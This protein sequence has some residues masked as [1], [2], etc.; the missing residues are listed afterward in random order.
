MGMRRRIFHRRTVFVL[1]AASGIACSSI[2]GV[3]SVEFTDSGVDS[4]LDSR[5]GSDALLDRATDAG[6]DVQG[7]ATG[8]ALRDA[9]LTF[10]ARQ[11]TA[12]T[13]CA[14]FD[15]DE[16]T[17]AWADG[18]LTHW[19]V[20]TALTAS[21]SVFR[22]DA[23]AVS[24]PYS[25]FTK[26][27]GVEAGY[28]ELYYDF[29]RPFSRMTMAFDVLFVGGSAGDM[30]SLF[31]T[32][33]VTGAT[34]NLLPAAGGTGLL[35]VQIRHDGGMLPACPGPADTCFSFS[36]QPQEG[37][38]WS[39]VIL[40]FDAPVDASGQAAIISL[41][42]INDLDGGKPMLQFDSAVDTNACAGP[43]HVMIYFGPYNT[44]NQ[45]LYVDNIVFNAE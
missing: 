19:K 2:L 13:F 1:A 24:P 8:D 35:S 20:R 38:P 40:T 42:V 44:K 17:T 12:P 6:G 15:E 10:C 28:A 36:D 18:G 43:G 34:C 41:S 23:E 14:D 22:S 7:D 25:L 9:R 39:R 16:A 5:A 32:S 45:A 33:D 3:Q 37:G 11:D 26:V 29:N 27:D 31:F 30:A 4:G 21:E